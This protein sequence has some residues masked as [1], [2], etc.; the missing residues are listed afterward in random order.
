[1]IHPLSTHAVTGVAFFALFS[2]QRDAL[3]ATYCPIAGKTRSSIWTYSPR[4][5][6]HPEEVNWETLWTPQSI[7]R[8]RQ[9][10]LFIPL[11]VAIFFPIGILTGF[12]TN[13]NTGL[14]FGGPKVNKYYWPWFCEKQ[15]FF[16]QVCE[17]IPPPSPSR[18]HLSL[19]SCNQSFAPSQLFKSLLT[20]AIPSLISGVWNSYVMPLVLFFICQ[21]ERRYRSLS[22][23]DK[24][25]GYCFFLYAVINNFLMVVFSGGLS[26]QLGVSLANCTSGL[27][28]NLNTIVTS[29]AQVC[30]RIP[31]PSPSCLHLSLGCNLNTIVTSIAQ[32]LAGACLYFFNNFI[33]KA[34]Y[35]NFWRIIWPH[36]GL[37]IPG[38]FRWLLGWMGESEREIGYRV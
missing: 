1:M 38:L 36:N 22:D 26:S 23:L 6:P 16:A 34:F 20:G 10:L 24:R 17:R 25:I 12:L 4:L 37:V 18:L 11:L 8:I 28:C 15:G 2:S 9:V 21:G 13:L 29:I 19:M 5:A 30:E 31:Q 32:A 14:C 3:H 35:G 7:K 27:G 33:W